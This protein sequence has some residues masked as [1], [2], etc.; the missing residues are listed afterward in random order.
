MIKKEVNQ[1]NLSISFKLKLT[2]KPQAAWKDNRKLG[3]G[4]YAQLSQN[5]AN[6]VTYNS[7]QF[8]LND[9]QKAIGD[10]FIKDPT[11]TRTIKLHTDQAGMDMFNKALLEEQLKKVKQNEYR[12]KLSFRSKIFKQ[13]YKFR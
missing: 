4:L 13:T 9:M 2:K 11:R 12:K 3:Q 10:L 1:Q 8:S 6:K 5:N 7:G